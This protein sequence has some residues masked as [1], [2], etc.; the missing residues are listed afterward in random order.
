MTKLDIAERIHSKTELSKK[1]SIEMLE[2]LL[3]IIKQTLEEGEKIKIAGFGNFEVK[4]KNDR[5]GR[6]PQSGEA[7]TIVARKILTFKPSNV[8]KQRI[9]K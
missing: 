3:S 2:N 4:Q 9:N 8:L 5:R 1:D 6:N 7:M